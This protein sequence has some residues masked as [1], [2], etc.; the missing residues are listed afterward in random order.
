LLLTPSLSSPRKYMRKGVGRFPDFPGFWVDSF[1]K[2]EK[3][4]VT[5]V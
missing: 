3:T 5:I 1:E 4:T 2:S